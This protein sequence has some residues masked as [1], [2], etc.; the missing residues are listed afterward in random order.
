MTA[1]QPTVA[2]GQTPEA[3]TPAEELAPHEPGLTD[4]IMEWVR[5]DGPWWVSSFVFHHMTPDVR[6]KALSEMV[7]VT[8][9]GG[10]ILIT[11]N[12][13]GGLATALLDLGAVD[14]TNRKVV[15]P[16]YLVSARKA[17]AIEKVA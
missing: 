16:I 17:D 5:Q 8:R 6:S 3:A 1:N 11:D 10:R 12:R 14:V 9:P 7:R 15:F 4:K 2:A 13:T